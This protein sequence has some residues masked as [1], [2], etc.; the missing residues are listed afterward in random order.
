[1]Y[2]WLPGALQEDGTV[3]TANRRLARV[4]LRDYSAR[5]VASG[6]GAWRSPAILSWSDWLD[7]L[8]RSA[9]DQQQLPTRINQHQSQLLW[10]RCLAKE[11]G[12]NVAGLT[13][14]VRIARETWQRLADW[15]VSIKE[16]ARYAQSDDQRI[17][18]AAAGRYLGILE[19]EHWID[20]AGLGHLVLDL[21]ES[22][23]IAP[24]GLYTFAGF[25]RRTPLVSRM[26]DTLAATACAVHDAP[27]DGRAAEIALQTCQDADAELRVA[28][29]W[30]RQVLEEEPAREVAIVVNQLERNAGRA[31]LL[32]R[33][34]FV[35]GWQGDAARGREAVNV[36]YGRRLL[37]Y[38]AVAVA[39]LLMRWL[40]RDLNALEIGHLLR[41]PLLV[42]AETAGRHR[43]EM[44]LR[45]L[46]D[47]GWSPS[48]LTAAMR[49]KEVSPDAL[50]WLKCVAGFT[51]LRREMPRSQSPADWA[52]FIDATLAAWH[53][54]GSGTQDSVEFQV[55]NRWR[56]LLND[57]ARMDLVSPQ[58]SLD[59]ALNRLETM[60]AETLFQPESEHARL[61]VI[62]PL[63]AAGARFDALWIS[64]LSAADWP[65]AGNPSPLLSR[66]LQIERGMP[67]ATPADTVAYAERVLASLCGAASIVVCSYPEIADDAEQAPSELLL[68][69]QPVPGTAISDPGWFAADWSGRTHVEVA[70]DRVP[71]ILPGEELGGGAGTLQ[72]QMTDPIAA[73]INGRLGVRLLQPQVTGLPPLLRGNIIHDALFALYRGKPTRSELGAWTKEHLDEQIAAA[74]DFAFSRQERFADSVL[75]AL[76][77]IERERVGGLLRG[78]VAADCARDGFAVAAVEQGIALDQGAVRLQLRADRIDRFEDGSLAIIDYKTGAAKKFLQGDGEPREI[79]L[80]AYA[81]AT[82]A[83]VAALALANVDAREIGFDGIGRGFSD[84]VDLETALPGW[85]RQ[86]ELACEALSRG[87]VRLNARQSVADARPLNLL[88]RFTEVRRDD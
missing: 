59:T 18:A 50:E 9:A 31:A 28:G 70:T 57:L 35:P 12:E 41:S 83:P 63:E 86:V 37:D 7:V 1:M 64:G 48:M 87:D 67:D 72:Q 8:L 26:R 38:P 81:C 43:L 82:D 20:G 24:G 30:A 52:I 36:S 32:V 3:I 51:K 73:F 42:A 44:R 13:Q 29:R 65:P 76:L 80:V 60:A 23:A 74:L 55:V 33:E 2:D 49:G 25:E 56:D 71:A 77:A 45:M 61:Q 69:L 5:Q 85:R 46:P 53:W 39:L 34:G 75:L 15:D 79:Q 66:Q 4:L 10:E 17:F 78:F 11:L 21:I 47:R 58:M 54:P 40:V 27:T 6:I 22:R 62:G 19:R 14:L 88:T 68:R 84:K 16:V